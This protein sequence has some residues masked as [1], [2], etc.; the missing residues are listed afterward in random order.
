M[1]CIVPV[2]LSDLSEGELYTFYVQAVN[3]YGTSGASPALTVVAAL[4]A[5][6]FV[7]AP[8]VQQANMEVPTFFPSR[9]LP[10]SYFSCAPTFVA[11]IRHHTVGTPPP[12]PL[13]CMPS[14]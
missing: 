2:Q 1:F 8:R 12:T 6:D 11:Q 5:G 4:P 7:V 3:A 10:L 14:L 9:L 13:S